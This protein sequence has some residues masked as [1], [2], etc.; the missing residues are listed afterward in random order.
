MAGRLNGRLEALEREQPAGLGA[1]TR[2][3]WLE[4]G[5]G[6]SVDQACVAYESV[7]NLIGPSE[8]VICWTDPE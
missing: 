3:H 8:G 7:G 2:W 1:V 6:Q 4:A 5:A